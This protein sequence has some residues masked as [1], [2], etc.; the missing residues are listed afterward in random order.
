MRSQS[1]HFSF[2]SLFS[3]NMA[4]TEGTES[5]HYNKENLIYRLIRMNF[6]SFPIATMHRICSRRQIL[7]IDLLPE[8]RKKVALAKSSAECHAPFHVFV[9]LRIQ[10]LIHA[11]IRTPMESFRASERTE[12]ET[13]ILV[14]YQFRMRILVKWF[15][16]L[17]KA[18]P[19]GCS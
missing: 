19:S 11:A 15:S 12:L 4:C 3:I 9:G 1:Y 17:A 16:V 5:Y 10:K 2:L 14:F 7:V 6:Y 18:L 8:S 13:M